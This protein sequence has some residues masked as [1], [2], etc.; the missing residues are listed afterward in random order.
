MTTKIAVSPRIRRRARKKSNWPKARFF[1][2]LLFFLLISSNIWAGSTCS[3]NVGAIEISCPLGVV[4]AMAAARKFIPAL[5]LAGLGAVLLV[6]FFGRAFC[7]WIC[8]GRWIFN[9]GPA[10]NSKPWRARAWMQRI[11]VGGVIGAAWVCQTPVFCVIC[12]AGVV[13]R[14][15]LAAGTGGS[16]LP[17]VGWLGMLIGVEWASGMSWC[18]DLC[19]LGAAFSRL[20]RLNPFMRLKANPNQCV[21]CKACSR[22]CPEGLNVATDTDLSTCTKCFICQSACPRDAIE[23]KVL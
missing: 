2:T 5:A 9:R 11:I 6:L 13:C 18:R 3:I 22:A 8:P 19:P 15:A 17:A 10:S 12:P 16:I 4:Q 14:G 7:S 20:S 21:P 1:A 23:L